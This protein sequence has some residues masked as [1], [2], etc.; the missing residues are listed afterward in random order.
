M[1]RSPSAASRSGSP[2][3]GNHHRAAR[4]SEERLSEERLSEERLSE[5]P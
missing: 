5:E 1:L 3:T 2:P 4:L